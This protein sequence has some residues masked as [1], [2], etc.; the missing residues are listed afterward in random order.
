MATSLVAIV[1]RICNMYNMT[2]HVVNV[3]MPTGFESGMS[4]TVASEKSTCWSENAHQKKSCL[5]S[6]TGVGCSSF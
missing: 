4:K 6:M 3:S 5:R 2:A 1:G